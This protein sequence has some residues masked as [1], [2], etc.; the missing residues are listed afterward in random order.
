MDNKET[1]IDSIQKLLALGVSDSE[2]AENLFDVG[3]EKPDAFALIR[4]A[5]DLRDKP[6]QESS[7]VAPQNSSFLQK[8]EGPQKVVAAQELPMDEEIA[9]Q[10]PLPK[11]SP[12]ESRS[13][14]QKALDELEESMAEDVSA[15]GEEE[16]AEELEEKIDENMR[17]ASLGQASAQPKQ[18]QKQNPLSRTESEPATINIPDKSF[19]SPFPRSEATKTKSFASQKIKPF[20]GVPKVDLGNVENE[21]MVDDLWKKGIVVAVNAKLSDMKKLKDDIDNELAQKVDE[22]IRKELY[23]FKTLMD[24]QKDLMISSNKQALEEKQ[25]EI[26]FIID[27]KI[28]ELKQYNKQ[29]SDNLATIDTAKQQQQ[30]AL[31]QINSAL[32]DAKRTKTQMIVEMNSEMIKTKSQAQAFIDSASTHL[33]QMDERINKTLELEK[34]IADG[35]LAQAEQKIETLTIQR[36]DELIS[37]LQLELNKLKTETSNISPEM[38]EQ[39]IRTLDEFKSQFLSSMQASLAQI[40]SAIDELNKKNTL[41][42]RTLEEKT[43]AIDAK[44]EELTK[45]EKKLTDRLSKSVE[46][47][48]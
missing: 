30:L 1:V 46:K 17:G 25:K 48:K 14:P 34:N 7:Q 22:S 3:I 44:L 29:I 2:I 16:N 21:M 40:N 24:S 28:A 5:K 23:Q 27:S 13:S 39:K 19:S 8:P 37:S 41:A 10:I 32:E 33:N 36:A 11:K 47:K 20:A 26:V 31:S 4:Q 35:M 43:L 38:L 6:K 42:E 45:F 18:A 9:N 12:D 15:E